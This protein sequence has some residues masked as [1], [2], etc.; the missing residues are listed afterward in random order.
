MEVHPVNKPHNTS[1]AKTA[2]TL[3]VICEI[4]VLFAN[5]ANCNP[6][7]FNIVG[8]V[9]ADVVRRLCY[10]AKLPRI[11]PPHVVSYNWVKIERKKKETTLPDR[12]P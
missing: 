4:T 8:I 12:L 5:R 6:C 7:S 3:F 2:K 10:D 11:K 9:G 1:A